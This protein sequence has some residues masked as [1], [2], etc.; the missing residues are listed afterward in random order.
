ME[1]DVDCGWSCAPCATGK[2]C[3]SS[4]DCA[5]AYCDAATGGYGTCK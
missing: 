3:Y 5:S 4:S 2:I 1:T